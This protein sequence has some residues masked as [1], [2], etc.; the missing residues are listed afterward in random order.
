APKEQRAAV[1]AQLQALLSLSL[2]HEG[3]R[4]LTA[5]RLVRA[6]RAGGLTLAP[7]AAPGAVRLL[8]IHGAKGLEAH[9]V[10]LLDTHA[11]PSRPERTGVLIDWPGEATHPQRFVF[12]TSEKAAPPCAQA[13][14]DAERRARS[15]EELNALYVAMTRAATRLVVSHFEPHQAPT[16]ATWW[17]R[18]AAVAPALDGPVPGATSMAGEAEPWPLP[19]LP[20]LQVA[21][22]PVQRESVADDEA[23]RWGQ[24]VHRLLQWCPT[25]AAGFD[26][27]ETHQR[28]IER[29]HGL[30]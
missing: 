25:P 19:T 18:L 4:Y 2:Q 15:L 27:D 22:E 8:T 24:A 1:L 21:P 3:G 5:Y 17:D 11:A 16:Q 12:F 9:T 14:L 30:D 7:V 26:W 13:L 28:A 29:A 10:L 20:T 23:T 6:V